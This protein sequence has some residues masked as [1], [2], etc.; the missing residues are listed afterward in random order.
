[1]LRNFANWPR[2]HH[3]SSEALQ[4]SRCRREG[5]SRRCARNSLASEARVPR[6]V[7]RPAKS[8]G[9]SLCSSPTETD[10]PAAKAELHDIKASRPEFVALRLVSCETSYGAFAYAAYVRLK[11]PAANKWD[12]LLVA[13]CLLVL[14]IG[15]WLLY[16]RFTRSGA[17]ASVFQDWNQPERMVYRSRSGGKIVAPIPG[18]A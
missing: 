4:A 11:K 12:I 6:R 10:R 8:I 7:E 1:V 16:R 9:R 13:L 5:F 15:G 17:R 2:Y 14:V 3:T 18:V